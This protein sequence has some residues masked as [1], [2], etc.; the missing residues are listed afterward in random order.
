MRYKGLP[1][2]FLLLQGLAFAARTTKEAPSNDYVAMI[3]AGFGEVMAGSMG[4]KLAV[5]IVAV[6]GFA[7]GYWQGSQGF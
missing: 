7:I 6:V 5:A 2:G 3:T 4:L 1:I